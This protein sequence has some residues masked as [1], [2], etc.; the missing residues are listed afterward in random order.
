M[1]LASSVMRVHF[2]YVS[3][4]K[5]KETLFLSHL[6]SQNGSWEVID[7]AD[8]DLFRTVVCY[9]MHVPSNTPFLCMRL[10]VDNFFST[11]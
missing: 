6:K 9:L 11:T 8:V 1:Y 7:V 5:H 2:T 4:P 10:F 3:V